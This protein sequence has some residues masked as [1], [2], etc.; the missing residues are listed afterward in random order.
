V[1]DD[2]GR[3]VAATADLLSES[4]RS[5]LDVLGAPPADTWPDLER[6][7]APNGR[8]PAELRFET[9]CLVLPDGERLFVTTRVATRK[10]HGG[11][12]EDS[13]A[14]SAW[15]A[16]DASLAG[17]LRDRDAPARMVEER[18]ERLRSLVP[19]LLARAREAATLEMQQW[20]R[21]V[22]ARAP[23]EAALQ[24]AAPA[25]PEGVRIR[26][27]YQP[28]RLSDVDVMLLEEA[29]AAILAAAGDALHGLGRVSDTF[30]PA[31]ELTTETCD[32]VL[33]RVS[34]DGAEWSPASLRPPTSALPPP[35]SAAASLALSRAR[36]ILEALGGELHWERSS[37]GGARF[38]VRFP[39]LGAP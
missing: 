12:P 8:S 19:P 23:L 27:N 13:P 34:S 21:S 24:A 1:L 37:S 20:A 15:R 35:P 30:R 10:A 36:R 22:D 16:V 31:L 28:A 6:V 29:L 2:R 26:R 7:F 33:L 18:T 5:P 38:V 4:R 32:G 25:L 3:V 9:V 11:E 39:M 14:R 17:T